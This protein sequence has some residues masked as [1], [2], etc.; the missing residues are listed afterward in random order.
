VTDEHSPARPAQAVSGASP[1][2]PPH[3]IGRKIIRGALTYGVIFLAV[4][5]LIRNL[6]SSDDLAGAV[7]LISWWQVVVISVLGVVNLATNWPPLVVALPGLRYREAA[8]T[9]TASAA[10]SNTIPEGGAAATGLNYAMLRSWGFSL[11]DTTDEVLVT[12]TWSQFTK[13]ILLSIGL[14]V[15]V[16]HGEAPPGTI[17]IALGMAIAVAIAVVLLGLILRSEAFARRLGRW[18][19]NLVGHVMGWFHK[20]NP[21][22]LVTTLP[23][24]RTSMVSLLRFCWH[25]LTV[26]EIVSQLTVVFVLGVACRMQGLDES[27]INWAVILVAWGAVTLASLIVPT[28][29]GIGVA[30]IVL[31]TVLGYG[32]PDSLTPAILGAVILYRIATFIVPIPIGL[33]TYFYWRKSTAWRRPTNSRGPSAKKEA[34][35]APAV[36]PG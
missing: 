10:L 6:Q 11:T 24:F 31:V 18:I 12:G 1:H 8:V 22:H 20:A 28:P 33:A 5:F 2:D 21:S 7:K 4:W 23:N 15:I 19:D 27:T 36:Q 13:Y 32:L 30:E 26:A 9:N 16:L 35:A 29:G 14:I 25:K 34:T 17:W 3:Q